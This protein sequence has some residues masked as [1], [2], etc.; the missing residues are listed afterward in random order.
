MKEIFGIPYRND[1]ELN[2][3]LK[4]FLTLLLFIGLG[5]FISAMAVGFLNGDAMMYIDSVEKYYT[6]QASF[7]ISGVG[8]SHIFQLLAQ[9]HGDKVFY[10]KYDIYF[11]PLVLIISYL[12]INEIWGF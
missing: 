8:L 9:L 7:L 3:N 5:Y 2:H 10:C 12:A 6:L 11:I 1:M 4:H